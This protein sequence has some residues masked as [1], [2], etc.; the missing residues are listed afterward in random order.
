MVRV[1]VFP[2]PAIEA[3]IVADVLETTFEVVIVN[4]AV[5]FPAATVAVNGTLAAD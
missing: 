4:V 2:A 3:E 1:A 5:V